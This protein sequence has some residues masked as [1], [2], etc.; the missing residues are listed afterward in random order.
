MID[1]LNEHGMVDYPLSFLLL[2][3][4]KFL[5]VGWW[6]HDFRDSSSPIATNWILE[7][8]ETWLGVGVWPIKGFGTWA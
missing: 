3:T 6:S 7:L 2:S 1:A 5:G 8:T 4:Y